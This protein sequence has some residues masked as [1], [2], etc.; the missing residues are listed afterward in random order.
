MEG[1]GEPRGDAGSREEDVESLEVRERARRE[2]QGEVREAGGGGAKSNGA[3]SARQIPGW[4]TEGGDRGGA[5]SISRR[6][7]ESFG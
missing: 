3:L 7:L 6:V 5:W 1:S 4:Q 2:R